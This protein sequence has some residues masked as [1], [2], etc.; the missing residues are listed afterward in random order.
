L[1]LQVV[2]ELLA[3]LD[4]SSLADER[5]SAAVE[6]AAYYAVKYRRQAVL[7]ALLRLLG[8][9]YTDADWFQVKCCCMF[10]CL[11]DAVFCFLLQYMHTL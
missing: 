10:C 8:P 6:A 1:L 4:P 5:I 11:G 9:E 3:L 7:P 2:Q